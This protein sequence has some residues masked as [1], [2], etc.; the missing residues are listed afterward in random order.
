MN[1]GSGLSIGR[2]LE[3]GRVSRA[4]FYRFDP[5]RQ[6]GTD[7]DIDLRDAMQRIALEWHSRRCYRRSKGWQQLL[8]IQ[9]PEKPPP[10]R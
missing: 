2:R 5:E 7:R 8:S 4:S 9:P 3:L 10:N 6:P 1:V